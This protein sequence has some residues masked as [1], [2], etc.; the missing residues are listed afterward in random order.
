[1][2]KSL[3]SLAVKYLSKKDYSQESLRK[4]LS[5]H[6]DSNSD[7]D[8]VIEYLKTKGFVSDKRFVDNIIDKYSTN[9][10]YCF[11]TNL[12]KNNGVDSDLFL[13]RISFLKNSEF[14]RACSLMIRKFP[15]GVSSDIKSYY[16]YARFLSNRGFTRDVVYKVI[17]ATSISID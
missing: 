1:M 6:C 7:I 12:L 15:K 5:V 17:K 16:K 2:I 13:E 8:D 4:K 10:G 3:L 11:I 9:Y 14:D